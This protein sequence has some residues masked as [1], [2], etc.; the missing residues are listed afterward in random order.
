MCSIVTTTLVRGLETRSM[1]PPIPFTILPW[2]VT[3]FIGDSDG[4]MG[5]EG[6]TGIIQLARSP[7]LD[8][9]I[10][11]SIVRL[12]WPLGNTIET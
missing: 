9:C 7:N 2:A 1:A 3:R 4:G 5:G 11:P 8:T 12:M 6:L 10:P